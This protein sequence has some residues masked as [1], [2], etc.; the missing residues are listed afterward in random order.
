V[1]IAFILDFDEH[2][3]QKNNMLSELNQSLQFNPNRLIKLDLAPF[4]ILCSE[5]YFYCDHLNHISL[6][7]NKIRKLYGSLKQLHVENKK[8]IITVGGNQSN[9]LLA[10]SFLPELLNLNVVVIVKGHEPTKYGS[11]LETLQRKKIPIHFATKSQLEHD[12]DSLLDEI[13]LLYPDALFIPEGGFNEFSHIGFQPL[14]ENHFDNFDLICVPVGTGATYKAVSKYVSSKTKVIGFGAHRDESLRDIGE[15]RFDYRFGGFAKMTDELF[16]FVLKFKEQ[17]GILLDPIYTS[18][19]L[20]EII[21]FYLSG[22]FRPYD[23]IV[24]IHTGGVLGWNGMAERN[25][26]FRIDDL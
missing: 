6:S 5:F 19:M 7:G 3:K 13:G 9:Y 1:K 23:S 24:A 11:V 15:V 16:Q 12:L 21:Q 17:Y 4:G 25:R 2:W 20:F 18:K 22:E 8:T 14:I 26:T 10:T